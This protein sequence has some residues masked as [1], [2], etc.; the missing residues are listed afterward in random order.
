MLE[1]SFRNR[2]RIA[3]LATAFAVALVGAIAWIQAGRLG[4]ASFFTGG[5]L[6]GS[7]LMLVLLGVRRRLPILVAKNFCFAI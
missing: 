6:L 3:L 2:R 4:R 7:I 5:T 1:I